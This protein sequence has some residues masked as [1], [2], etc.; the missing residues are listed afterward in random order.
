MAK[1]NNVKQ[2]ENSKEIKDFIAF[3][4]K[5]NLL[6]LEIRES[7]SDFSTIFYFHNGMGR[8]IAIKI[9]HNE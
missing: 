6:Q 3:L 9:N 1:K 2:F 5:E 4:F 8:F 7:I